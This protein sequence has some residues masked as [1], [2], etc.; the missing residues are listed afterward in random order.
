MLIIGT[1]QAIFKAHTGLFVF[2]QAGG[3]GIVGIYASNR[4]TEFAA[5]PYSYGM[6]SQ[7]HDLADKIA[8]L[9]ALTG[10]LRRENAGLRQANARLAAENE[11]YM[12]R[13]SEAQRRVAALLASMP[14]PAG[15][16]ERAA[17][18]AP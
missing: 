17:Q 6:I 5:Q 2:C 4:L 9:A 10:S 13:L 7:V 3:A 15:P 8:L 14:A 12:G 16:H 11:A 1:S 18:E